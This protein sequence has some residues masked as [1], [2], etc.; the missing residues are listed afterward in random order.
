MQ[1]DKSKCCKE[2]KCTKEKCTDPTCTD[3]KC[4][5]KKC[6]TKCASGKCTNPKC[7]SNA[8]EKLLGDEAAFKCMT[9]K[10]HETFEKS[11]DKKPDVDCIVKSINEALEKT[12]YKCRVEREHLE[13][14]IESMCDKSKTATKEDISKTIRKFLQEKKYE[15]DATK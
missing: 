4:A 6:D 12:G 3:K 1:A 14:A 10:I 5:E 8:V 7:C 13:H 2:G 15:L 11:K 9:D